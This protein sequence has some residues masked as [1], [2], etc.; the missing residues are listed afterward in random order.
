M[1][2]LGSRVSVHHRTYVLFIRNRASKPLASWHRKTSSSASF[3]DL[4]LAEV[5]KPSA[6]TVPVARRFRSNIDKELSWC[7]PT[8][9]VEQLSLV[10]PAAPIGHGERAAQDGDAAGDPAR[11]AAHQPVAFEDAEPSEGFGAKVL[12]LVVPD[13]IGDRSVFL[14]QPSECRPVSR[15]Q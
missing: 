2:P 9:S 14:K 13:H 5:R 12:A 7:H 11:G 1:S 4:S 10:T 8:P 6:H 15:R 3:P